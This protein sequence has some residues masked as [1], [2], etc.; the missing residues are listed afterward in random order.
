MPAETHMERRPMSRDEVSTL[1]REQLADLLERDPDTIG[2]ESRF[3]E[4]L[5]ADSL[6]LVELVEILEE[7]L[8]E[9]SCSV[10][11]DDEDLMDLATVRETVD[12]IVARL[13]S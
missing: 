1:V 6:A 2:E 13:D 5:R 10:M 12:Y 11:F 8:A 4:D 3:A 7:E 9:R